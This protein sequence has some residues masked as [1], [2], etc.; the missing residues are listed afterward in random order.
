MDRYTWHLALWTHT[1]IDTSLLYWSNV[2]VLNQAPLPVLMSRRRSKKRRR[3][4]RRIRRMRREEDEAEEGGGGWGRRRVSSP[5]SWTDSPVTK[6]TSFSW[7]WTCFCTN[8]ERSEKRSGL[9]ST[10]LHSTSFIL[11]TLTLSHG[12]LLDASYIANVT[13]VLMQ[14]IC[15]PFGRVLSV[16]K[17]SVWRV[18]PFWRSRY[19]T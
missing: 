14:M 13:N 18:G 12:S 19:K 16:L 5:R 9:R 7:T 17:D 15:N 6:A 8:K 3:R 1:H 4:R 11:R 2:G 10:P